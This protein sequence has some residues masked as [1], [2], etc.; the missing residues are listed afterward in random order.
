MALLN[1]DELIAPIAGENGAGEPLP[2]A[3]RN[4]LEEGLPASDPL[5]SH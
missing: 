4:E 3:V 5:A 2:F 1:I